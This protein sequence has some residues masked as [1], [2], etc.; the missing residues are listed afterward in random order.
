[1]QIFPDQ[2]ANFAGFFCIIESVDFTGS[3]GLRYLSRSS[4]ISGGI[5]CILKWFEKSGELPLVL[6]ID[7]A[8]ERGA[9]VTRDDGPFLSELADAAKGL[10]VFLGVALDDDIASADGSK[11]MLS[12]LNWKNK[13]FCCLGSQLKHLVIR[14]P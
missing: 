2:F 9:R 5:R 10:N 7:T 6:L 3:Q 8:Y 12:V 11:S 4:R 14:N 13:G 1:M